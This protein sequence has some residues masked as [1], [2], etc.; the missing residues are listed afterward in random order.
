MSR[1][2]GGALPPIRMKWP[3]ALLEKLSFN[4]NNVSLDGNVA[5]QEEGLGLRTE[6]AEP[7]WVT[8]WCDIMALNSQ[9]RTGKADSQHPNVL[10]YEEK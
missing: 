5:L 6:T 4:S 9:L 10:L 8:C 2:A 3:G 7:W 1:A